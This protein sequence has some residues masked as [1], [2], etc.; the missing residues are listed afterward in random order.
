MLPYLT[1][2]R[3]YLVET[4]GKLLTYRPRVN[5]VYPHPFQ[6]NESGGFRFNSHNDSL[7]LTYE[8]VYVPI[9]SAQQMN[10]SGQHDWENGNYVIW[11]G[12]KR[13]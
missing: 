1:S 11:I 2:T 9:V 3:L 5:E 4:S 8:L 13:C 12:N 7:F 6:I 10:G